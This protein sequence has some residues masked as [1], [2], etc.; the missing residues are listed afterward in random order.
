MRVALWSDQM[1]HSHEQLDDLDGRLDP[2]Q[3][4]CAFYERYFDP[5]KSLAK[6]FEH[7]CSVACEDT[8]A[9]M[10]RVR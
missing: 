10:E 8:S 6:D 5:P 2:V 4:R 1:S 9:E 3:K 7:Y